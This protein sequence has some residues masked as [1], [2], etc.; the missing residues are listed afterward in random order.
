MA[1]CDLFVLYKLPFLH[2]PWVGF[3]HVVL[4]VVLPSALSSR[5][6]L[7]LPACLFVVLGKKTFPCGQWLIQLTC[8]HGVDGNLTH[9]LH[10]NLKKTKPP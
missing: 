10:H 3:S 2:L 8:A 1:R 4:R 9:A 5:A 6:T 7:E